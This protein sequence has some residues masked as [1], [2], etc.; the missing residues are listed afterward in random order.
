M[1]DEFGAQAAPPKNTLGLVGFILAF[2][3]SPLGLILSAVALMKPP[4]GFAIGG[5]IVGLLGTV[6]WAIVAVT[7][8]AG[9][10]FIMEA[11]KVSTEVQQDYMVISS[12][13]EGAMADGAYPADL[14]GLTLDAAATTD[15]WGTAYEY[16]VTDDGAGWSLTSAGKDMVMGTADDFTLTNTMGQMEIGNTVGDAMG[17]A[18]EAE[19]TG[20]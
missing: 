10:E 8:M 16:V 7:V 3:V 20:N 13:V 18:M 5:V 11:I 9:G 6:G 12:A 19:M 15:P 4:R 17:K 1:N 14:A 2:C